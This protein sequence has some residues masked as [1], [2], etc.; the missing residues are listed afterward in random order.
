MERIIIIDH[1]THRAY[2]EDIDEEIL[3][4]EYGGSEEEY[5]ADTYAL[6]KHWTWDFVTD[7]EYIPMD[8]DPIGL[9]PSDLL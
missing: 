3:E 2:I 8:G 9:E 4:K 5:I 7:I 6:S 1:E